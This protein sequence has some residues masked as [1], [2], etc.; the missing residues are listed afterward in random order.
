[1]SMS[2]LFLF[3]LHN[4]RRE[5]GRKK[6]TRRTGFHDCTNLL[7][8]APSRLYEKAPLT[9]TDSLDELASHIP[10]RKSH[11]IVKALIQGTP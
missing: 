5:E 3:R 8:L 4:L 10:R 6:K 1:M 9:P 2:N 11:Q 7:T